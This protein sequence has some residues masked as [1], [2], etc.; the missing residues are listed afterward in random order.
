M[1][2][3]GFCCVWSS[4]TCFSNGFWNRAWLLYGVIHPHMFSPATSHNHCFLYGKLM[5]P[6]LRSA[7]WLW[8][9]LTARRPDIR[10]FQEASIGG[11][12]A[13]AEGHWLCLPHGHISTFHA[14]PSTPK[15]HTHTQIHTHRATAPPAALTRKERRWVMELY[16]GG[17]STSIHRAFY[18]PLLQRSGSLAVTECRGHGVFDSPRRWVEDREGFCWGMVGDNKRG[19]RLM[20]C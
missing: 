6:V 14:T 18:H 13:E 9:S 17:Q 1:W 3:P 12:S 11:G 8:P 19:R 7:G 4:G 20:L 2:G 16:G 15:A 5:H 10:T